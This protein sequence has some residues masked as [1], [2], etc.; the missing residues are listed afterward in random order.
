MGV[1]GLESWPAKSVLR[2]RDLLPITSENYFLR[3]CIEMV[4]FSDHKFRKV[5]PELAFIIPVQVVVT[6]LSISL[7]ESSLDKWQ[8]LHSRV[9]PDPGLAVVVIDDRVEVQVYVAW[10]WAK[11]RVVLPESGE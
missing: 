1:A 9:L 6:I 10:V 8:A 4:H 5:R 11:N 2:R 3:L 7:L